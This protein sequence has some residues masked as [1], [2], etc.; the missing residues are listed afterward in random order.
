MKHRPPILL[1][2]LFVTIPTNVIAAKV[3]AVMKNTLAML[4]AA[5]ARKI[6]DNVAPLI[7]EYK[8]NKIVAL[9]SE[10][11]SI[12]AEIDHTKANSAIIS[13]QNTNLFPK[14]AESKT[15]LDATTKAVKP[16]I[17][18]ASVIQM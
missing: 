1:K 8:T 6:V 2:S 5:Y 7:T 12:L 13:P 9:T 15:G 18:K 16:V 17:N 14:I 4:L 3:P 10:S 11:L